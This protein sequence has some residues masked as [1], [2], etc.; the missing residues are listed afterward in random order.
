MEEVLYI[1]IYHYQE[2][3]KVKCVGGMANLLRFARK[4][5]HCVPR[6]PNYFSGHG[7]VLKEPCGSY[8][9]I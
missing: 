7:L 2:G 8:N 1:F 4:P 3:I 5:V 9:R 6:K